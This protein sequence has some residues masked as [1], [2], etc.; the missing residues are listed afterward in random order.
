[1]QSSTVCAE[2]WVSP[3]ALL[4]AHL[5]PHTHSPARLWTPGQ[6]TGERWRQSQRAERRERV[7]RL[8]LGVQA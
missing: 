5:P 8:A 3:H 7:D 4:I 1:M 2:I 6:D